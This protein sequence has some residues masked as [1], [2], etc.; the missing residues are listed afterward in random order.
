MYVSPLRPPTEENKKVT[1]VEWMTGK[2]DVSQEDGIPSLDEV[3]KTLAFTMDEAEE[4]TRQTRLPAGECE[5]WARLGQLAFVRVH[6]L[7]YSLVLPQ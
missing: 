3:R 4:L 6:G 5:T 7:L 1:P 2:E